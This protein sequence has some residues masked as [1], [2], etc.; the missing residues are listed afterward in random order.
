VSGLAEPLSRLFD[1]SGRVALV[2]GGSR[3]IGKAIARGFALAGADVAIVAR[4]EP[5]LA[6]AL[7]EI[8]MGT[9]R[10]GIYCSADLD[11]RGEATRVADEVL[12][13]LGR[14]DILVSNAGA[15]IPEPVDE[16]RDASWDSVLG[17][18]VN[19]AMA[20]MRALVPE[21]KQRRWGRVICTSSILGFQGRERRLAYS[22]AKGALIAMVRSAAVE[23]G[24]FGITVNTVAPGPVETEAR[25]WLSPAEVDAAAVRTALERWARPEELVAPVLMLA[26]DGG[27]YVTGTT[28]V[29]DGGWLAK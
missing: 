2:T 29:V 22:A 4:T 19:S 26:G 12:K 5:E 15:S 1:L 9:D 16:I 14:I 10:R 7:P 18:H 25:R 3:G 27:S 13:Q 24:P 23:L 17:V 11:D 28:L 21:M 6:G 8:L 20:L